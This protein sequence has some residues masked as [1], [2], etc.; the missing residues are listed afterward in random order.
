[1]SGLTAVTLASVEKRDS[2]SLSLPSIQTSFLRLQFLTDPVVLEAGFVR[3][4]RDR[5]RVGES[6]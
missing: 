2:C 5:V 1:M 6:Q 4:I 3:R